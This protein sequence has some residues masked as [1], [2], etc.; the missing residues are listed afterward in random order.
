MN[1]DQLLS[2]IVNYWSIISDQI[3]DLTW[4]G[5]QLTLKKVYYAGKGGYTPDKGVWEKFQVLGF[6]NK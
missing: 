3:D 1:I 6:P 4:L 2:I 5:S